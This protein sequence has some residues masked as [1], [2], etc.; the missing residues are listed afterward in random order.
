MTPR[1][2]PVDCQDNGGVRVPVKY[3]ELIR[4][5]RQRIRCKKVTVIPEFRYVG[6]TRADGEVCVGQ[7]GPIE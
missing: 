3:K 4:K 5:E 1:I 2:V 6:E 7:R